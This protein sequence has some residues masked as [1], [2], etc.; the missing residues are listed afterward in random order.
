MR[1]VSAPL[2]DQEIAEIMA[3]ERQRIG[4]DLHDGLGQLLGGIALKAQVI[5]E[6]LD[7]QHRPEAADLREIVRLTNEAIGQTR[8]LAR[9]LDPVV[10]AEKSFATVLEK[11]ASETSRLFRVQCAYVGHTGLSLE[12]ASVSEHL[13]RVAQEAINNALRHGRAS[14]IELDFQLNQEKAVMSVRDDGLGLAQR[15]QHSSG[16]GIRIMQHRLNAI[17]GTFT[18]E[19]RQPRGCL[20]QC[21][22]P[23][24]GL[25][26]K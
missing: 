18:I 6:T 26:S 9:S 7:E 19:P 8:L 22:I 4:H 13:F 24:E 10:P 17:G 25:A 14:C 20:V 15:P 11:L 3:R 12:S 1:D 16:I 2:K 5:Y 23:R 21:R